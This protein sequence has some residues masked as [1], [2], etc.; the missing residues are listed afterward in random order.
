VGLETGVTLTIVL[1]EN[2]FLVK[3]LCFLD[4][5]GVCIVRP[6]SHYRVAAIA[7]K[8]RKGM[9]VTIDIAPSTIIGEFFRIFV[10]PFHE[11]LA[12]VVRTVRANANLKIRFFLSHL[13]FLRGFAA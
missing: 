2:P 13:I 6:I 12:R 8:E 3:L 7:A 11:F 4:I 9:N 5:N 1:L 10:Y